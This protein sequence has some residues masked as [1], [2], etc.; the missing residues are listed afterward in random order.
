MAFIAGASFVPDVSGELVSPAS[1]T[2]GNVAEGLRPVGERTAGYISRCY[3]R[4]KEVHTSMRGYISAVEAFLTAA[5]QYETPTRVLREFLRDP[6]ATLE[7]HVASVL[8]R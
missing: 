2:L 7:A 8:L 6:L 1:A 5:A 3:S 4:L